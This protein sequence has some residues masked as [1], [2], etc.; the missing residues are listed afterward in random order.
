MIISV[1]STRTKCY[2]YATQGFLL[3]NYAAM[4]FIPHRS[5]FNLCLILS[6][7]FE[8]TV[9]HFVG[10]ARKIIVLQNYK[11]LTRAKGKPTD[12]WRKSLS[13][14]ING[15]DLGLISLLPV[16]SLM[17]QI[18]KKIDCTICNIEKKIMSMFMFRHVDL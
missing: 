9:G 11:I 7:I 8:Q 6:Q 16:K 15:L 1:E 18:Q 5:I 17:R 3:V 13:F 10:A 12:A 14:L 2:L 4:H